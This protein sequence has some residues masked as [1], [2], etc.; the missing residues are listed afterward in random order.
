MNVYNLKDDGGGVWTNPYGKIYF[1]NH[2]SP[3]AINFFTTRAIGFSDT[4]SRVNFIKVVFGMSFNEDHVSTNTLDKIV[5]K[6][7]IEMCRALLYALPY[8]G[9]SS[10]LKPRQFPTM[11]LAIIPSNWYT[12]IS[13]VTWGEPKT[14]TIDSR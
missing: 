11:M 8:D 12:V 7:F 1:S 5:S 4:P 14:F 13:L 2:R 10:S 9:N 6:H 3:G